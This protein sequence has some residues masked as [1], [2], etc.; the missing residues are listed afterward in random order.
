LTAVALR[1]S[2]ASVRI[3]PPLMQTDGSFNEPQAEVLYDPASE[4]ARFLASLKAGIPAITTA[5][6]KFPWFAIAAGL[7]GM[8]GII[9]VLAFVVVQSR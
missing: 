3:E 2:P 1:L 7:L 4:Q 9:S 6:P 8:F 5:K